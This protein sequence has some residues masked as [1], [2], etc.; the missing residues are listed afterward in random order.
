MTKANRIRFKKR[1]FLFAL[2]F[3]MGILGV[4]DIIKPKGPMY[5]FI[6]DLNS[7]EDIAQLTPNAEKEILLI[8]SFHFKRFFDVQPIINQIVD[9]GPQ[10]LFAEV[11]PPNDYTETYRN[12]LNRRKGDHYYTQMI[13]SSIRF[14]GMDKK[15]AKK[16]IQENNNKVITEPGNIKNQ[17]ALANAFFISNN[18]SN[19][20]LQL[21]YIRKQVDSTEYQLLKKLINKSTNMVI[22]KCLQYRKCFNHTKFEHHSVFAK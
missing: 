13:D 10:K 14:T 11:V 5:G 1:Y 12:Y 8:G 20:Y 15:L 9:F 2:L 18:E 6:H 3:L 7:R 17:I 16:I 22:M 21:A 4:L 19:G